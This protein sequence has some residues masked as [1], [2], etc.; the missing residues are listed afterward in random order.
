M[1]NEKI[2]VSTIKTRFCPS[3]TGYVHIGNVRTALFSVLLALHAKGRMLLR[4]ED[5][6]RTRSYHEYTQALMTDLHW[7]EIPWHEGAGHEPP[8]QHQPYWQSQ[9][10]AIYDKYYQVLIEKGRA[11]PCFCKEEQLAL[12]RKVQR[13]S[14]QPPRYAGTCRH[15]TQ[16]QIEAKRQQGIP[17][18]LRFRVPEDQTIEFIDFVKGSQHFIS[19]DIGDFIIRRADGSSPFMY[20]NA[21]DDAL[22]EVTHVLRGDDHLTN[23]PRQLLILSALGLSVP[24]Y[25]HVS[26]I[27]GDD[28][29]P[30]SKRN[31]S[32]SIEQLRQEGYLPQAIIN[33]I[34]RLGHYYEDNNLM[35][36]TELAAAFAPKH[37][38]TSPARFELSQLQYWQKEVVMALADDDFWG[39]LPEVVT[40]C[41]PIK[42]KAAFIRAIRPNMLFPQDATAWATCLY[43]SEFVLTVEQKAILAKAGSQFFATAIAA[44]EQQGLDYVSLTEE[45]KKQCGVKGKA[46]FQP[47]RIALTGQTAGPELAQ[48]LTL[49]GEQRAIVRLT[50]AQQCSE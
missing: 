22:M 2:H 21:L 41:V 12:A 13:A 18:T 26:L 16:T 36:L 17:E 27:L 31:G 33:Y 49:M 40:Q 37:L 45:L 15:L 32:R 47:L 35:T 48:L 11:F 5:T 23:T 1:K 8:G 6:D 44:I 3:P 9:R 20:S 46:L 19:D 43:S 28:K 14:G 4:I 30:L 7:L 29:L 24:Q 34:A 10:Q 42:D 50:Q 25:G 38:S 39:W